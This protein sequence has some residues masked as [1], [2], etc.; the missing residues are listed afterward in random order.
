MICEFALTYRGQLRRC[1]RVSGLRV[2]YDVL[3]TIHAACDTH[4]P[5][6]L[7]EYPEAPA[8]DPDWLSSEVLRQAA[9]LVTW[10]DAG[11]GPEDTLPDVAYYDYPERSVVGPPPSRTL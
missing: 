5:L 10:T 7:A 1:G 9:E 3:G 6:R 11:Y 4:T 2:W 8:P